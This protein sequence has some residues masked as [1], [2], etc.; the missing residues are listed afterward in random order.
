MSSC[1]HQSPYAMALVSWTHVEARGLGC[2][3]N[4][5]CRPLADICGTQAEWLR[6]QG[7]HGFQLKMSHGA[8][9]STFFGHDNMTV[10]L[11]KCRSELIKPRLWQSGTVAFDSL[12]TNHD[13]STA[14]VDVTCHGRVRH[15][16][17]VERRSQLVR[18]R[19]KFSRTRTS[20]HTGKKHSTHMEA[21]IPKAR[22]NTTLFMRQREQSA[23]VLLAPHVHTG[24]GCG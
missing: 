9:S 1:W 14:S 17:R 15:R 24:A 20:E 4:L 19:V 6:A 22:H 13:M 7:A 5:D 12:D 18:K 11:N 2:C 8:R 21:M 10:T 23:I 16:E 3:V